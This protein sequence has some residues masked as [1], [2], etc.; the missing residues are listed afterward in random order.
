MDDRSPFVLPRIHVVGD[1]VVQAGYTLGPRMIDDFELVFFPEGTNTRYTE[2]GKEHPLSEPCFIFSR[3][4]ESHSYLFDEGRDVRHLFM[5]F[6]HEPLRDK[7]SGYAAMDAGRMLFP[8]RQYPLA[9]SIMNKMIWLA[10]TQ[11]PNW[12]RRLSVFMAAA[13]EELA[14]PDELLASEEAEQLPIPIQNALS[15]MEEKL[16][17]P[18]S[19]K[20]VSKRSGWT[21]EHFTRVFTSVM[22]M[23]PKHMLLEKR[24]RRAE[25]MML[26]GLGTIKQI[27]YRVGFRDEHHFSRTYKKWR[28]ITAT[29]YIQRCSSPVFRHAMAT[30]DSYL[31]HPSNRLV[32]VTNTDI[33]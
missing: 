27:A 32:V 25:D 4:G 26:R 17:E 13:L 22:G 11:P 18:L 16:S 12:Q 19:V 31:L 21:H 15:Y 30:K 10:C 2:E 9:A 1:I 33:K 20:E 14:A 28:G 23:S 8:A 6:E 7:R 5:H 3:P 29:E 24:L